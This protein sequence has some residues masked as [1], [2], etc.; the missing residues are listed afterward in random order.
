MDVTRKGYDV[1]ICVEN[2]HGTLG[3]WRKLKRRLMMIPDMPS[4]RGPAP[5]FRNDFEV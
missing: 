1:S 4:P 5:G 2:E 3:P